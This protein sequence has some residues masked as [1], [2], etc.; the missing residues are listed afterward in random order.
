MGHEWLALHSLIFTADSL[1]CHVCGN[2]E[3]SN[4]TL[5][6]CP[7]LSTVCITVT[8]GG[9]QHSHFNWQN[10]SFIIHMKSLTVLPRVT[11]ATTN[12]VST[13]S[14]N[15]NCSSLLTCVTPLDTPTEWSV[16]QG[17]SKTAFNQLCCMSDS[18]NFPTVAGKTL[19]FRKVFFFNC[20]K[21]FCWQIE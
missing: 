16:N 4:T 19:G 8:A 12:L 6:T 3:C 17:F 1:Q 10:D 21:I 18:C 7:I 20:L 15:K 2:E 5:V 9:C 14:V 11:V 13:V